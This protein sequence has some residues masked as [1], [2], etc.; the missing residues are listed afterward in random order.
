MLKQHGHRA[1]RS[2]NKQG[3]QEMERSSHWKQGRPLGDGSQ[4]M[5][6]GIHIHISTEPKASLDAKVLA[7]GME[8]AGEAVMEKPVHTEA[9]RRGAPGYCPSEAPKMGQKGA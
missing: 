5:E 2:Q 3:P 9:L 1:A 8:A 6:C 4:G 7:T